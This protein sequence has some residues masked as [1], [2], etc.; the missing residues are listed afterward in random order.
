[1]VDFGVVNRKSEESE[2]L[3]VLEGILDDVGDDIRQAWVRKLANGSKSPLKYAKALE[4]KAKKLDGCDG[5]FVAMHRK[6]AEEEWLA[7]QL[8]RVHIKKNRGYGWPYPEGRWQCLG[9]DGRGWYALHRDRLNEEHQRRMDEH[10][11]DGYET[12]R[13]SQTEL[14]IYICLD[15]NPGGA[16]KEEFSGMRLRTYPIGGI[17]E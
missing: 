9:C 15:C 2:A 8:Q 1:M 14:D 12:I 4:R 6:N 13:Y 11:N 10:V 16:M 17:T 5:F 7:T 3:A